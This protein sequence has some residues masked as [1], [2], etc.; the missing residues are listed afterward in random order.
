[1]LNK[2]L[3][4]KDIESVDPGFYNSV[5]WSSM[6]KDNN[7]VETDLE[8]Y[9]SADFEVLGQILHNELKPGSDSIRFDEKN[10]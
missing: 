9:F 4:S 7:L 10:E 8:L 2:A 1:M 5:Q 6:V 3:V